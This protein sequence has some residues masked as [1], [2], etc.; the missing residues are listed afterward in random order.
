MMRS[1][2]QYYQTDDLRRPA[3]LPG[4]SP[5]GKIVVEILELA[6]N[7]F[8]AKCPALAGCVARGRTRAEVRETA[9]DIITK[10]LAAQDVFVLVNL[11]GM[12]DFRETTS[13]DV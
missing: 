12:V 11:D 13:F 2:I 9:K 5:T 7:Q 8:Q 1:E 6:H 10:Y 3:R 4:L